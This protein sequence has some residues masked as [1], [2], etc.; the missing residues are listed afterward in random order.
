MDGEAGIGLE[1]LVRDA[2]RAEVG[3]LFEELR[4]FVDRRIAELSTEIHATVEMV[5]Y[6]E[7]NLSGKLQQMH[8]QLAR[9]VALP[10][11][12]TRNSGIELEGIVNATEDAANRI[13]SAA[14]AIRAS[15]EQSDIGEKARI[16]E[17]VNT[18]F[19]ACSFQDLT[20]QRV[21]RA[22]QQL[23]TVEDELA[24]IVNDGKELPVERARTDEIKAT[25]AIGGSGPELAQDEVDKLMAG[26]T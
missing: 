18:I 1:A 26:L 24:N 3:T 14:E 4:R 23:Q 11:E 7:T 12:R 6:S 5:D 15:I 17:Q 2:V 20:G 16:I 22:L 10:A 13:L 21:R 25:A 9:V 8:E 19:E